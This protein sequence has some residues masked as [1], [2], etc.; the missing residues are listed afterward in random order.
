[1]PL[2]QVTSAILDPLPV[3]VQQI[4]ETLR[5][6][7][8]YDASRKILIYLGVMSST[9]KEA[10]L[11]LSSSLPFQTAVQSLSQ[12][13]QAGPIRQ[14]SRPLARPY[15]GRGATI[16]GQTAWEAWSIP[17]PFNMRGIE[18]ESGQL[19]IGFQVK[20]DTSAAG[21][22]LVPCYFAWLQGQ[23]WRL[24]TADI[25]LGVHWDHI[26]DVSINGFTFRFVILVQNLVQSI[27]R[28]RA[29]EPVL[30]FQQELLHFLQSNGFFVCWLGIQPELGHDLASDTDEVHH[31]HS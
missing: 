9:D 10:L 8:C 3:T 11:S 23:L 4:P 5:H 13:S 12:R 16:A 27:M 28:S 17:T 14:V 31:G 25:F 18:S 15:L 24:S 26:E 30:A 21:F 7:L 2:A 1:V 20:V 6:K 22:T 19:Q 29:R